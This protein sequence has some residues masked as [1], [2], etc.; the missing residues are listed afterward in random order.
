MEEGGRSK[1]EDFDLKVRD[2]S[3]FSVFRMW[4][5]AKHPPTSHAL[6]SRAEATNN[7]SAW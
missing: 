6:L 7:L 1:A 4:I 2:A 3:F 5:L